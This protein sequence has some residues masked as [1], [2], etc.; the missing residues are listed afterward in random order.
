VRASFRAAQN[1]PNQLTSQLSLPININMDLDWGRD[2][3]LLKSGDLSDEAGPSSHRHNENEE[4]PFGEPMAA[5]VDPGDDILQ[6]EESQSTTGAAY[7][8]QDIG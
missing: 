3:E 2:Y 4:D 6:E 5:D 8:L 7:K 1:A